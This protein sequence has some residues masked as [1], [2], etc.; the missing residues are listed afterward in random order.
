MTI[1]RSQGG[2]C[3]SP[4]IP[5]LY[6][7]PET[8]LGAVQVRKSKPK[9]KGVNPHLEYICNDEYTSHL[10]PLIDYTPYTVNLNYL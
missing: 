3:L 1:S 10:D 6:S 5:G 9:R 7:Q 8:A 2:E 4:P